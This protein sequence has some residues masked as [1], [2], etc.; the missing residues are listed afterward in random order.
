MFISKIAMAN[1]LLKG[2]MIGIKDYKFA[3]S[4]DDYLPWQNDL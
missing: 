2:K 3:M 1:Y 4:I